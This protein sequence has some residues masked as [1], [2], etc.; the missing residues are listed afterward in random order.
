MFNN[1]VLKAN[2]ELK[3]ADIINK[4]CRLKFFRKVELSLFT[5]PLEQKSLARRLFAVKIVEWVTTQGSFK[6]VWNS[7]FYF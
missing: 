7:T 2:K 5:L 4:F 3:F 6:N 1:Y